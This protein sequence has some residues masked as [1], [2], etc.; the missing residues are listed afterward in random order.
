M[1]SRKDKR[2]IVAASLNLVAAPDKI[3]EVDA[4]R[5]ENWETDHVGQLTSRRGL[6]L[7]A[8]MP[9]A[10]HS[11]FR[12]ANNRYIGFASDLRWGRDGSTFVA[13]GF[14]GDRLFFVTYQQSVWVMNR[15]RQLRITGGFRPKTW[16]I[17]APGSPLKA[18]PSG[19]GKGT[20]QFTFYV[21]FGDRLGAESNPS[22]ASEPV[23]LD[24]QKVLLSNIPTAGDPD[25]S[26]R[27]IYVVGGGIS[28][29]ALRV[30]TISDRVT[31]SLEL[32]IDVDE[33]QAR[34]L[35]MPLDADPPPPA[36]GMLGPYFGKLLAW[37]SAEHP[38]RIWWTPTAQPWKW[39]GSG[40]E[41]EGN[42]LDV[43]GD[44]EE[45][46]F[47]T[48]HPGMVVIYKERSIWRLAGDPDTSDPQ[49][50]RAGIG[51]VGPWAVAN[52]GTSD[53]F[54]SD[55]GV[56]RFNG[57]VA[58]EI[59]DP[60]APMFQQRWV[61][62]AEN[63]YA[64]PMSRARRDVSILNYAN[65]RLYVSYPEDGQQQNSKT[66]IFDEGTKRWTNWSSTLGSVTA[67][68]FE[69]AG[70]RFS[71]LVA[72]G[73]KVYQMDR[74]KNDA[75]Q[76]IHLVWQ[77]R[78]FDQGL[79]DNPKRYV[80]LTISHRT[81]ADNENPAALTVKAYFD[82]GDAQVLG[83]ISS[84]RRTTSRFQLGSDINGRVATNVSILLE[85]D[86]KSDVQIYDLF[87]HYYPEARYSKSYDSGIIDVAGGDP[88]EIEVIQIDGAFPSDVTVKI[89]T[90]LPGETLADRLTQQFVGESGRRTLLHT[91]ATP[92]YGRRVRV[93]IEGS[94]WFQAFA[95]KLRVKPVGMY[96]DGAKG[97]VWEPDPLVF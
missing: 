25:V 46:L 6:T 37:S 85:G 47:C 58:F 2:R 43:G 18:A 88:V 93:L 36:R 41:F 8:S 80:E 97:E 32:D 7:D 74:G 15:G 21:T 75:G 42:W 56:F 3:T 9:G 14:D 20:G 69:G 4:L 50:T 11:L 28:P 94:G 90:D 33:V 38:N 27:Y 51:P 73:N 67:M 5:I 87:I 77:S 1:A 23:T 53:Y 40:D 57:D 89:Q 86:A 62:L 22:P 52:A 78:Y 30:A 49:K 70:N 91:L 76:P 29:I 68:H 55:E 26:V 81:G 92:I 48:Q 13:N 44:D 45:I 96:I 60:L 72:L 12:S 64:A 19:S 71:N 79:P 35:E 54:L 66:L 95:V 39:P 83:T 59:S 82:N 10:V 17:E 61:K 16:G 84:R 63:V 34:N 24:G 65:G 31:T